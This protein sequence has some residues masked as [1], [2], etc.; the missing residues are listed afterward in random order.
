[1]L[2]IVL[3]MPRV[4]DPEAVSDISRPLFECKKSRGAPLTRLPSVAEK[5]R[6]QNV[7]DSVVFFVYISTNSHE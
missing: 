7:I 1:M 6:Y 5:G 4:P 3:K 2:E